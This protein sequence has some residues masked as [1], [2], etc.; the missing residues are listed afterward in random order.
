MALPLSE[1]EIQRNQRILQ[2]RQQI[3][4][5]GLSAAAATFKIAI[6]TRAPKQA[7]VLKDV[8][9]P[10]VR[11]QPS[12]APAKPAV[13]YKESPPQRA[14]L[15]QKFK[16]T[17]EQLLSQLPPTAQPWKDLASRI[18]DGVEKAEVLNFCIWAAATGLKAAHVPDKVL[19]DM[20]CEAHAEAH[21]GKR[22]HVAARISLMQAGMVGRRERER[23]RSR[24]T[25][26]SRSPVQAPRS[27]SKSS[28]SRD[29]DRRRGSFSSH[30]DSSRGRRKS[31]TMESETIQVSC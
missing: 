11:K 30:G 2:N 16:L 21:D 27:R 15:M 1:F 22:L 17:Q 8:S 26:T 23:S 31:D 29:R 6:R 9:Q 7:P 5:L 24:S 10:A 14:P 20:M 25:S 13:D 28:R 4:N 3:A 18:G 12:R 19:F